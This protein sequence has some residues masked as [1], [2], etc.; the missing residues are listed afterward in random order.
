MSPGGQ[1]KKRQHDSNLDSHRADFGVDYRQLRRTE[2]R[3]GMTA[4]NEII[5]ELSVVNDQ[6]FLCWTGR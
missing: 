5:W 6:V 2:L 1:T 3:V 4:R